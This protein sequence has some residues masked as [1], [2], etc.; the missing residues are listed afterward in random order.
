ML[1]SIPSPRLSSP[2]APQTLWTEAAAARELCDEGD[3]LVA[4][5]IAGPD[6]L[7]WRNRALRFVLAD[8][9]RTR[10]E[11]DSTGAIATQGSG[12][13]P[14][15]GHGTLD[16]ATTQPPPP[17]HLPASSSVSPAAA[18]AQRRAESERLANRWLPETVALPA[19]PMQVAMSVAHDSTAH[20]S[21][22]TPSHARQPPPHPTSLPPLLCLDVRDWA[23]VPVFFK[24]SHQLQAAALGAHIQALALR[25][26]TPAWADTVAARL[27]V[28]AGGQGSDDQVREGG[29]CMRAVE[30]LQGGDSHHDGCWV[31]SGSPT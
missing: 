21:H 28:G 9:D 30:L 25:L 8:R 27:G 2:L 19:S 6:E 18:L 26:S 5:T 4:N 16:T 17:N 31:S 11:R 10:T 22:V 14:R 7:F 3:R 1:L 20:A 13:P 23:T 15:G 12:V 24:A 29:A